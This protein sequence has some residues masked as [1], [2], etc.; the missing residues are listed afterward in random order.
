M[1]RIEKII[2]ADCFPGKLKFGEAANIYQAV[3][4][5]LS[6]IPAYKPSPGEGSPG[7]FAMRAAYNTALRDVRKAMGGKCWR[8]NERDKVSGVGCYGQANGLA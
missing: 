8:E 6:L 5:I 7:D 1:N 4:E 3:S 2:Q